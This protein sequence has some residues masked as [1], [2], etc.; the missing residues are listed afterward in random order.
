MGCRETL[1]TRLRNRFGDLHG[2]HIVT[3][4]MADEYHAMVQRELMILRAKKEAA[5]IFRQEEAER[6]RKELEEVEE[7]K[8]EDALRV[9]KNSTE[10][11]CGV[12][13]IKPDPSPSDVRG[14]LRILNEYRKRAGESL[15]SMAELETATGRPLPRAM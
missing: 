6:E 7:L 14:V 12:L 1:N 9:L 15:W 10:V 13:R 5:E 3:P 4:R 11:W 8:R 2:K